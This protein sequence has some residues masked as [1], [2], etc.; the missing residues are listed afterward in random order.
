MLSASSKYENETASTY[1]SSVSKASRM[2]SKNI[3][4]RLNT[5]PSSRHLPQALQTSLFF[6]FVFGLPGILINSLFTQ[7]L[8]EEKAL[9]K[10]YT[11]LARLDSEFRHS[12]SSYSYCFLSLNTA[13]FAEAWTEA[14][15]PSQAAERAGQAAAAIRAVEAETGMGFF[16]YLQTLDDAKFDLEESIVRFSKTELTPINSDLR[17]R[18]LR[19]RLQLNIYHGLSQQVIAS[20]P[21]SSIT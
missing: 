1:N 2:H 13:L 7:L 17:D 14:L 8:T 21:V 12:F 10:V 3:G 4:I 18:I 11:D 19:I 15:A 9:F 20:I 6:V 5:L 16:D